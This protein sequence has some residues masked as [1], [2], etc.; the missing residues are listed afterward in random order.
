MSGVALSNLPGKA[1]CT[2]TQ[3]ERP[4]HLTLAWTETQGAHVVAAH[5]TFSGSPHKSTEGSQQFSARHAM[6]FS[7]WLSL[8][9]REGLMVRPGAPEPAMRK[10]MT[11]CICRDMDKNHGEAT[12]L[13]PPKIEA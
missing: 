10:V 2:H 9:R 12:S 3:R 5:S 8:A 6:P 11:E 4:Q 1:S 13:Y 7:P